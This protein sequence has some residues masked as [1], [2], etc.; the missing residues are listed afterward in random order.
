MAVASSFSS[1]VALSTTVMRFW[2]R[3]P[4]LSEQMICVEPRVSTAVRRLMMAFLLLMLVTPTDSTMVTTVAS[5]SGMAAT[6]R[7]TAIMKVS[8]ILSR[9]K[10]WLRMRLNAKMN[11][12]MPSTR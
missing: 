8:R 4:V 3:V 5:P 1:A 7:D 12:Q 11:A 9:W 2:V 6:A 10:S